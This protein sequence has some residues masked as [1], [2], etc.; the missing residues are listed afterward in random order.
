MPRARWAPAIVLALVTMSAA[1]PGQSGVGSRPRRE[2]SHQRRAP[3]LDE[4]VARLTDSVLA[5]LGREQA[6]ARSLR[7][8]PPHS[9]SASRARRELESELDRVNLHSMQTA[10]RLAQLCHRAP[11]P[12]GW[13][14]ITFSGEY[15]VVSQ[16]PLVLRFEDQPRVE[17]V[18]PSSPA[19][20]AGVGIG[21]TIVALRG[22]DL[23]GALVPF[24]SLLRAGTVLAA[25]FRRDGVERTVRMKIERRPPSVLATRCG[26][27]NA[28]VAAAMA[29]P[30]VDVIRLGDGDGYFVAM[31]M[32]DGGA[33]WD[34]L[35]ARMAGPEAVVTPLPPRIWVSGGSAARVLAGAEV[36]VT[37][38]EF[39]RELGA[40]FGV[41]VT[42]VLPGSPAARAGI[43]SGD[44]LQS[45]NGDRILSP[46]GLAK[47]MA[48]AE[49]RGE[50]RLTLVRKRKPVAIVLRWNRDRE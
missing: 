16:V 36:A 27:M 18:D 15:E 28:A 42:R 5:L 48:D 1:A 4:E 3:A 25:T 10:S 14:G 47:A 35:R 49:D 40:R 44:V 43:R 8:L 32:P 17:A 2:P 9:D 33:P 39:L 12:D 38:R 34:P 31:R 50:L 23:R 24:G 26:E 45:A 21:D 29:N 6:I 7:A 30:V 13:M 46:G 37:D 22:Q 41:L 19:A 20:R 11:Q